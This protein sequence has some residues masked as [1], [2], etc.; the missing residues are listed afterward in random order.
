M[1][2][3]FLVF[4]ALFMLGGLF[5]WHKT[6]MINIAIRTSAPLGV[7]VAEWVRLRSVSAAASIKSK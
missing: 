3:A 5:R 2:G 7:A 6:L 1:W 4:R